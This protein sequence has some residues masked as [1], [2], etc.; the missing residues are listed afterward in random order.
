MKYIAAVNRGDMYT[1]QQMVEEAAARAGYR[2][3]A[4]HWTETE[5]TTFDKK[6]QGG[7]Y[8]GF[9][10]GLFFFTN[11]KRTAKVEDITST[12]PAFEHGIPG[13]VSTG[14]VSHN[15]Q[16]DNGQTGQSGVRHSVTELDQAYM[17]AVERGMGT[18][19]NGIRF[20]HGES[21]KPYC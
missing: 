16:G 1:A 9:S 13:D 20:V 5:F 14:T 4:Y 7:N 3:R 19:Q 6:T 15:Q 21:R 18:Q 11:K 8:P 10:E 17:A 12:T 2:I